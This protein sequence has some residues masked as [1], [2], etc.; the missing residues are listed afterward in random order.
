VCLPD[1]FNVGNIDELVSDALA[2][3]KIVFGNKNVN[4]A[5]YCFLPRSL[6][7]LYTLYY[8]LQGKMDF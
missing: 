5:I 4:C 6:Y 3:N 2:D 7:Q 1:D 8:L